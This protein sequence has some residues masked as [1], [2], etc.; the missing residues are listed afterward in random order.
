MPSIRGD[1]AREIEG[2]SF[3]GEDEGDRAG[4][5]LEAEEADQ[6]GHDEHH[7]DG[8]EGGA[9]DDVRGSPRAHARRV[10]DVLREG[11]DERP[12]A[13]RRRRQS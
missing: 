4:A 2:G 1:D 11:G 8:P 10:R 6:Q 13:K 9:E 3:V 7:N 5:V 12:R